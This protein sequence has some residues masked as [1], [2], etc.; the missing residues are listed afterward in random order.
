MPD[1]HA[2]SGA[3]AQNAM[4]GNCILLYDRAGMSKYL[5]VGV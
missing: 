5:Q 3:A 1:E 2:M 4:P